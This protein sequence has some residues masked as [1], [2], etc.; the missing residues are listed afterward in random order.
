[1]TIYSFQDIKPKL[2]LDDDYWVAPN[3]QVIG[4]VRIGSGCGIW[5]GAVIRGDNELITV[6]D[7]TNIQENCVLHTDKGLPLNIGENCTIGHSAILHSCIIGNNSLIGMSA[8][9]LNGV[10]IGIN[11]LIGAGALVKEGTEIPDNSLVVGMPAKVIREIK[12][13]DVI[14]L[15]KSAKDYQHK[16]RIFRKS[17]I[18]I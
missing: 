7:G 11:C 13:S 8:T 9:I 18:E 1:M 15:H 10:K 6:G 14:K 3:A 17:L 2:P 16:M 4:K 5:F 12:D